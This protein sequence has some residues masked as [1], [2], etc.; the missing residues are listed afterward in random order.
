M[1]VDRGGDTHC[2]GTGRTS[3]SLVLTTSA[4]TVEL[5]TV[6]G[7]K[8]EDALILEDPLERNKRR[9]ARS[10]ETRRTRC[11]P[12]VICSLTGLRGE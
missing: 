10:R 9:A 8:E 7:E 4:R 6:W 3:W 1:H 11:G 5:A 12:E 2:F